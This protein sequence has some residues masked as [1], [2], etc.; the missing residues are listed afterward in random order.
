MGIQDVFELALRVSRTRPAS[1]RD[2]APSGRAVRGCRASL[3]AE[4]AK[5]LGV[6]HTVVARWRAVKKTRREALWKP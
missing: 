6:S 2:P 4:P 1:G 5:R 3:D